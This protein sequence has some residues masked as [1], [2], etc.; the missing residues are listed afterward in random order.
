M[1]GPDLQYFKKHKGMKNPLLNV[2]GLSCFQLSFLEHINLIIKMLY[3]IDTH[4]M[5]YALQLRIYYD[6]Y[7][8]EGLCSGT[9]FTG[10]L[11]VTSKI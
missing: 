4:F 5:M 6:W 3:L 11:E 2:H 1:C 7:I 9:E 10:L 8:S